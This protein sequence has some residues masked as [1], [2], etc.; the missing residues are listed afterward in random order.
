MAADFPAMPSFTIRSELHIAPEVFWERM[1]LSAVNAELLPLVRMTAPPEW[2][3][4]PLEQW[5]TG[6]VLFQ[7][8]ILL[9]GI[10]PVDVHSFR[11]ERIDPGRG[12][13]ERSQS[14]VNEEWRHERT[15]A[16]TRA[17]CVITDTVTVQGR[18]PLLAALLLPVYRLIFRHRHRRLRALHGRASA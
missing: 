5:A 14:W 7:S 18:V 1:T 10:V 13:L 17:G 16:S 2:R 12:F 11:L 6:R 3:E 8:V 15:T 9:F 4:R